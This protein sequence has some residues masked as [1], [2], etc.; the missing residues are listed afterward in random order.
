MVIRNL[1]SLYG[2]V[3]GLSAVT[4]TEKFEEKLSVKRKISGFLDFGI[5]ML[6]NP[7]KELKLESNFK[8]YV[9]INFLVAGG[10]VRAI[11]KSKDILIPNIRFGVRK[12][13]KN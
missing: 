3:N 5:R 7:S 11:N 8:L 10:D 12:S 2:N 13:F 6:I 1:L 9:D 4:N